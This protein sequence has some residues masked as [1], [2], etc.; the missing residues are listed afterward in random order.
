MK[1]ITI[2]LFIAFVVIVS[3][4]K[5]SESIS[6]KSLIGSWHLY[7][8]G[9]P[10]F[11]ETPTAN[12]TLTFET[13]GKYE[14]DSNAVITE[15]GAYKLVIQNNNSVNDTT[16]NFSPATGEAYQAIIDIRNDSLKLIPLILTT[17]G[18]FYA[19][20]RQ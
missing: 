19:Y 5:T 6:E 3:C 9:S 13:D 4:K 10:L 8:F 20:S 15:K 12:M 11:P 7:S 18:Y 14:K 17:D 16:I 1:K 2:L